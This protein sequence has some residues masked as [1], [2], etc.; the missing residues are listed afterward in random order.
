MPRKIA[1]PGEPLSTQ[2]LYKIARFGSRSGIIM[3]A[4]GKA[5]KDAYGWEAKGHGK[6]NLCK[7][8]SFALSAPVE[9]AAMTIPLLPNPVS[10][11]PS[12]L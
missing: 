9:S 1:F 7:A 10:R 2:H 6:G 3:T 11:L 12:V 5:T 4:E 8:R